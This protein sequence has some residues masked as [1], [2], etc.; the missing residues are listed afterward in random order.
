MLRDM[1]N[2]DPVSRLASLSNDPP[3]T[4]GDLAATFAYNPASQIKSTTR[5]GDAYAFT[6]IPNANKSG[7]ANG[8]NQLTAYGG[9][10]FSHDARG[11]VTAIGAR[12]FTYAPE[13][14]LTAASGGVTLYYDPLRRLSEYDTTVSTRFVYDGAHIAAEVDNPAGAIQ[15]RFVRGDGADE[16]LVGYA[17]SGTASRRFLSTDER[18]SIIAATDSAGALVGINAYDEYGIPGAANSGRFQ[19]TGQAWLPELGLHYYKARLYDP[20]L[21]RFLQTDPIGSPN[22]YAYVGNDSVNF[23]DPLGLSRLKTISLNTLPRIDGGGGGSIDRSGGWQWIPPGRCVQVGGGPSSCMPGY[24]TAGFGLADISSGGGLG[25][26]RRG[27]G[28]PGGGGTKSPQNTQ[29]PMCPAAYTPNGDTKGENPSA[30]GNRYNTDLP[31]GY[32][33]ALATFKGLTSL[34][35]IQNGGDGGYHLEFDPRRATTVYRS[36]TGNIGLRYAFSNGSLV[37]RVDI[38]PNTFSL[39]KAETIHFN[40]SGRGNMCPTR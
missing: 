19:Y 1:R 33:A 14:L 37:F 27:G 12:T 8:L 34:D 36:N 15:R 31:G 22:L 3:G 30:Q 20:E 2:G 4:A 13:N 25:L 21:G 16:L 17:G 24:W 32:G 38:N 40:G 6:P 26:G 18:G 11:N 39:T 35:A 10:A 9:S 28:E 5:T 29:P 23:T 7:T